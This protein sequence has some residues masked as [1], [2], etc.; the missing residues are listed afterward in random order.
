MR[1]VYPFPPISK[2]FFLIVHTIEKHDLNL[3]V[4]FGENM[5]EVNLI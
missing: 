3:I 1:F 4:V 5:L 2:T